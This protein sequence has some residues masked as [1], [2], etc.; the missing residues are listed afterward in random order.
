MERAFPGRCW[1][2]LRAT[3]EST[4]SVL[5]AYAVAG[6]ATAG[7]AARPAAAAARAESGATQRGHGVGQNIRNAVNM[8]HEM[9]RSRDGQCRRADRR[10]TDAVFT[11]ARPCRQADGIGCAAHDS[12]VGAVAR[13]AR[14]ESSRV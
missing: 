12:R 9:I 1:S 10:S 4:S 7:R 11:S 14:A 3:S 13:A 6:H 8:Y 5:P 2:L